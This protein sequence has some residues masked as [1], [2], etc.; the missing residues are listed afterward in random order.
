LKWVDR[1]GK[2]IKVIDEDLAFYG[3]SL[4]PDGKKLAVGAGEKNLGTTDVWVYDLKNLSKTRFTF[5]ADKGEPH[6]LPVWSPDGT[7]I[8][9]SAQT[10]GHYQIFVKAA[11]GLGPETPVYPG[12]GERYGMSWSRDGKYLVALDEGTRGGAGTIVVIPMDGSEQKP[13]PLFPGNTGI[14]LYSMP[15]VSPN[16]KWV[17][18]MSSESGRAE[19]YLTTFPKGE[20]KWQVST[21]GGTAPLWSK[22][23]KELFFH[24]SD[25]EIMS[26]DVDSSGDA[27][28]ISN[29]HSLFYSLLVTSSN[30]SYDVALDGKSFL[31]DTVINAAVAEPISLVENWDA[32]VGPK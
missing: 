26:A 29:V 20:G 5:G 18:Y 10:G 12:E 24:S 3:P 8:A 23:G 25:D 11:N 7:R 31:V 28:G 32:A 4:S 1:T 21:K 13:F 15:R 16:G 22:D 9:F 17:A 2:T 27:P 19:V 6:R 30:W 14:T